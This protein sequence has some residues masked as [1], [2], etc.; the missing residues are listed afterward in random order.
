M[1]IKK[2]LED[3]ETRKFAK[4]YFLEG[5]E[6]ALKNE[7]LQTLKKKIVYPEFNWD[8][9]YAE[10]LDSSIFFHSLLSMPFLS[11]LKVTVVKNAGD[12]PLRIIAHLSANANKIP[13]TNCLLLSDDKLS[14]QA[15]QLIAKIGKSISFDKLT[16]YQIK[17][18]VNN[19]LKENNKHIDTEAFALLSENTSKNLSLI[20]REMEKLVSYV[21][22]KKN[23][24]LKDVERI[25]TDTKTYT[26]YELVDKISEKNTIDSL[27]ILRRLL[28]SGMSPQQIIGMLRWQ[29][30]KLWEV[31]A[32]ISSG[33]SSYK[34]LG[35]NNIPFFKRKY[36][37]TQLN[38]FNWEKLRECFNLLLNTDIQIKRGAQA[39]LNLELLL[40][41]LTK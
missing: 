21:G 24:E 3:F 6:E 26:I 27:N 20:A 29:F 12:L 37:L 10:E 9:Y 2:I 5:E 17:D 40:F 8:N 14:S 38:N 25:G 36:F 19:Y 22:E 41:R 34:A 1:E 7:F 11:Q 23:I 16:R 32:L 28:V 13:S 31:K 18:W 4:V 39:D 33:I 30:S 35:E 15:E